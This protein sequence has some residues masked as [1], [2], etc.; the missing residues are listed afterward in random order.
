MR[1]FKELDLNFSVEGKFE[2]VAEK[3]GEDLRKSLVVSA[4][5][6][7]LVFRL[8]IQDKFKTFCINSLFEK[9]C[10]VSDSLCKRK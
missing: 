6:F 9:G 10:T 2:G 3:V 1:V 4:E 8:D 7:L 5:N